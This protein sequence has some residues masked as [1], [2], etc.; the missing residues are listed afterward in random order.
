M[1]TANTR[2]NLDDTH[3]LAKAIQFNSTL[4]GGGKKEQYPGTH[5]H[6]NIHPAFD[7]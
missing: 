2:C 7:A 3:L 6:R 5:P 1:L 4:T